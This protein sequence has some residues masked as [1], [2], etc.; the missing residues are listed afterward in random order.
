[1]VLH[2]VLVAS[3]VLKAISVKELLQIPQ[4]Q[5]LKFVQEAHT[6]EVVLR[7]VH[8]VHPITMLSQEISSVLQSP[9]ASKRTLTHP[10]MDSL[11]AHKKLSVTGVILPALHALMVIYAQKR[12]SSTL[13]S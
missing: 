3:P 5:V 2:K 12:H 13:L 10:L 1:M 8:L 4:L 7:H 9:P 11:F 6:Q